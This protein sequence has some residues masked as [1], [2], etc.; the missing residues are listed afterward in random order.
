M[1]L[2][3]SANSYGDLY[4]RIKMT[5]KISERKELGSK[6]QEL[7]KELLTPLCRDLGTLPED[8]E[9]QKELFLSRLP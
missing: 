6:I 1:P 8:A 9:V 7:M 5:V 4:L 2:K 3:N